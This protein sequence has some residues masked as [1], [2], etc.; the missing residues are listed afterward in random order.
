MTPYFIS[1][2]LSDLNK[3]VIS[4]FLLSIVNTG[5]PNMYMYGNHIELDNFQ[6]TISLRDGKLITKP[7]HCIKLL[8]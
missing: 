4:V 1:R 3:G 7:T 6:V 8:L 2:N 5:N